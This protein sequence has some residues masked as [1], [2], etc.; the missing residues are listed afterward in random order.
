MLG[1]CMDIVIPVMHGNLYEFWQ[2]LTPG[3][4]DVNFVYNSMYT[5][6]GTLANNKDFLSFL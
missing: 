6:Q 3:P 2:S 1:S 5:K 4:L